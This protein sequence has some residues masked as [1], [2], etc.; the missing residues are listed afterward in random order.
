MAEPVRALREAR[1]EDVP[2]EGA[3]ELVA[4]LR[5]AF[6][7]G[8]TRPAAWRK[9][10]LRQMQRLLTEG[11]REL[12]EALHADLGRAAIES[13]TAELRFVWREIDHMLRNLDAWMAP[14]RVPVPIVLRP[15]RATILREPLG[16]GLVIGP[17][18]YPVHLVLL[19]MAAAISAGNAVIGKPSEITAAT[20]EA[21][22]RLVPRYLD[23]DAA[24]I[25]EGGVPESQAL[26]AERFD[27]IFYTGNGRIGRIVMEAAARHLTPVTLELGGK[28]PA[29]VDRDADLDVAARRIAFGKFL[30]AG[31]TCVAPDYV[32]VHR[33]AEGALVERLAARVREFYGD[34]PRKSPDYPR[35]VNDQHFGRLTGLLEAGGFEAV[36]GG[37]PAEA[38]RSDRYF[39]PTILRG[40][41]PDAPVM[42]EEIFG[43]IL[44]VIGVDGLDQ[45]IEFVN[46]RPKP[47]SLYVFSNDRAA[48]RRVVARTSSGSACVNTCVVQLAVPELPFGGVGASGMGAYH[49]RNGFETFSHRKSVLEKPTRFEPPIQYPP[50]TRLRRWLLRRAL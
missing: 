4:R 25:V 14:E 45:A 23:P 24:A 9:Q 44:P 43:P 6:D 22:A 33:D 29:I 42:E 47:L 8:R 31:Q 12:T 34:D 35:I 10:Q 2:A 19:P 41:S 37:G 36:M 20:S 48:A 17:W 5:R 32:L 7:A 38:D 16:V 11:E 28:S 26:L 18:N 15:A 50:Y 39:P 1:E 46:A 49:G 40:V 3:R 13:W 27:H 21:I 30:N